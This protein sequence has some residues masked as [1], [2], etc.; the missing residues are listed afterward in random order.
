MWVEGESQPS[1][2]QPRRRGPG[3]SRLFRPGVTPESPYERM[4]DGSPDSAWEQT[5]DLHKAETAPMGNS[6]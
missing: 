1:S 2:A 6:G 3:G 4:K 5:L